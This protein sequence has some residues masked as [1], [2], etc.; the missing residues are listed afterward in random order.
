M[1]GWQCIS[2]K[3]SFP[4]IL[5]RGSTAGFRNAGGFFQGDGVD[6][7]EVSD[8]AMLLRLGLR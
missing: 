4:Q 7:A 5:M 6:A 2:G 1:V 8:S 3:V